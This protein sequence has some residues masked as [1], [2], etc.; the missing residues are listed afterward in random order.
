MKFLTGTFNAYW[1]EIKQKINTYMLYILIGIGIAEVCAFNLLTEG[2]SSL[3]NIMGVFPKSIVTGWQWI[4]IT[5]GPMI[6]ALF[7]LACICLWAVWKLLAELR[8]S[9]EQILNRA[10][11]CYGD[12]FLRLF[13]GRF[14]GVSAFEAEKRLCQM[15]A[16]FANNRKEII[17]RLFKRSGL[18]KPHWEQSLAS[19]PNG[20]SLTYRDFV[21]R[22]SQAPDPPSAR[23]F[24]LLAIVQDL[25]PTAGFAGTV[26]ALM[27]TMAGMSADLSQSEMI[28]VLLHN[29]SAAFGS[30]VAGIFISVP[31]Y[32]AGK[33]FRNYF[34]QDTDKNQDI[35][36]KLLMDVLVARRLPDRSA[37]T[38]KE[39]IDD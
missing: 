33:I 4:Y 31:A 21:L 26:L 22:V 27:A 36:E 5:I 20:P 9:D 19:V 8:L 23:C 38:H 16:R 18:Y 25:A 15:V 32:L 39:A 7:P 13:Q 34:P 10:E 37:M 30:T 14:S 11:N 24:Y 17:G 29:S 6:F 1:P 3:K 12:Y 2:G 28:N 35:E